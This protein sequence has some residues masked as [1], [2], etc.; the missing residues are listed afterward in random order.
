MATATLTRGP[1]RYVEKSWL[2]VL[3]ETDCPDIQELNTL[4][5]E[6]ECACVV[7]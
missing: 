1:T 5:L 2:T 4:A 7:L 6:T 3:R